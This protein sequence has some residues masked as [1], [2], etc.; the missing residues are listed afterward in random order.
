MNKEKIV[1]VGIGETAELATDYFLHDS[2]YEICAYAAQKAY[3]DEKLPERVID[4]YPVVEVES[5]TELYPPKQYKLFVAMAYGKMN[6]DRRNM[7]LT[8]KEE[9]Y[10]F[11]SYISSYAYVGSNVSI[12]ENCFILENNVIQRNV[13]IGDNVILWSGNHIGH[14]TKI[15]DHVFLSSH[16]AVS[17]LCEIGDNC[18]LGINCTLGDHISVAE[19]CFIGGGVVLMHDT[20]PGELY[21]V[22]SVKPDRLGTKVVFGYK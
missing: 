22:P 5:L 3:I 21:R 14:R 2:E 4:D 10:K 6:Y 18:F 15:H 7:Y 16:V 1:I 19:N 11:V 17:G 20:K 8:L 13:S 12:G 9:G